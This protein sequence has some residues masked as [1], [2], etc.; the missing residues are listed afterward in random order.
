MLNRLHHDLV[1]DGG[2]ESP[3]PN[4]LSQSLDL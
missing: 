3:H 2:Y 1:D 4:D